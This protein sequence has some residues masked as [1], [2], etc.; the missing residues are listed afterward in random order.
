MNLLRDKSKIL[1]FPSGKGLLVAKRNAIGPVRWFAWRSRVVRSC[2]LP[3]S[4][5]IVDVNEFLDKLRVSNC[6]MLPS[7]G[8][9]VPLRLLLERSSRERGPGILDND[10]GILPSM[11]QPARES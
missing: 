4:S 1:K 10:S 3:N 7:H 8:G 11:P 2:R 5:G 6:V 9:M